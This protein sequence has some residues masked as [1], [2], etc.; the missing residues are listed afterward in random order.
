MD[1]GLPSEPA[2]G[3]PWLQPTQPFRYLPTKLFDLHQGLRDSK[4]PSSTVK[5]FITLTSPDHNPC[6]CNVQ[7]GIHPSEFPVQ[8]Q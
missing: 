4:N 8:V 7:A 5:V 1:T 2:S 6:L 3:I